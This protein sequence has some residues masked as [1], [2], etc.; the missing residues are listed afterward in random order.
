MSEISESSLSLAATLTTE[1]VARM[2]GIKGTTWLDSTLTVGDRGTRSLY[3]E[4]PAFELLLNNGILTLATEG[5]LFRSVSGTRDALALL[6]KLVNEEPR[7]A[8]GF[9]SYEASLDFLDLPHFRN[10]DTPDIHFFIYDQVEWQQQ[11]ESLQSTEGYGALR[12]EDTSPLRRQA[13]LMSGSR[14]DYGLYRR[15]VERIKQHIF[16]G[17]IYQAN[18]THR[19][20]VRSRIAPFEAYQILRALNPSPYG[21]YINFGTYQILSSS[22]ERMFVRQG[23]SVTTGPIKGTIHRGKNESQD[24]ENVRLLRASQK[25]LAEHLM[26]V[27]LERNDLGRIAQIGTVCVDDLFRP[28]RYSSLIHLTSDISATLRPGCSFTDLC[29]AMLPGGSIS[30]APKRRAV[31]IL[32][33][34]EETPRGVYTGCIGYL[35]KDR[36]DFNIAIRTIVH[37]NGLYHVHAGGAIVAD[38]TPESEYQEMLLKARN[39]F[40][41]LGAEMTA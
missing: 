20:D 6:E 7:T 33:E 26:I 4:H 12:E 23:D 31:E 13:Q 35:T 15:Q 25:D 14:I 10:A 24:Q 5:K 22:P 40:R 17:D 1:R 27:D 29:E 3:A 37:Q 16:E 38:S 18:L 41:A 32:S 9:I 11:S 34:I 8:I 30:G 19:F 21:A 28:E 2:S 39:M 36:A